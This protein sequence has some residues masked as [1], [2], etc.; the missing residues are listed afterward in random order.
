MGINCYAQA[1]VKKQKG[2]LTEV[3]AKQ[4]TP[5]QI[6]RVKIRSYIREE[7]TTVIVKCLVMKDYGRFINVLIE[8]NRE[9]RYE[10]VFKEDILEVVK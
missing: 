5:G 8:K 1:T 2:D 4:Y 6:V 3:L 9:K 7:G 10:S